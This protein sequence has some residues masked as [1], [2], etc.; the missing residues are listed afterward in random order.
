M[1]TRSFLDLRVLAMMAGWRIRYRADDAWR[2]IKRTLAWVRNTPA[3][4]ALKA[5]RFTLTHAKNEQD[6]VHGLRR[7]RVD[8]VKDA[9][10]IVALVPDAPE[11]SAFYG[12]A[13]EAVVWADREIRRHH[14]SAGQWI[15][16]AQMLGGVARVCLAVACWLGSE[17]YKAVMEEAAMQ[18]AR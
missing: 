18:V 3:Y 14:R 1:R 8:A 17:S 13:Y 2:S 5:Q 7:F 6:M 16:A 4:L 10:R 15:T 12:S 9:H 11:T